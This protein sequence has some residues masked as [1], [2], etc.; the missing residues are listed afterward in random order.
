M[1]KM[2]SWTRNF[3]KVGVYHTPKQFVSRAK[4]LRHPIDATD[5]LEP[6]TSYA[7]NFNLKYPAELVSLE[8]KKNLL[9]AKL[10]AVQTEAH[11]K[12]LHTKAYQI[13][14]RRCSPENAFWFGNSC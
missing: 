3:V 9:F 7:L 12:A 11:E 1:R 6:A 5:H 2:V 4:E 14:W 10:L 8:R 13:A